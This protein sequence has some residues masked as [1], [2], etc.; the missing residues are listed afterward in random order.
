MAGV[1]VQTRDRSAGLRNEKG[2]NRRRLMFLQDERGHFIGALLFL[3]RGSGVE[4]R[5]DERDD[6]SAVADDVDLNARLMEF[7]R[8]LAA[9]FHHVPKQ[10]ELLTR[11]A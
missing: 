10:P 1:A 6:D 11:R 9:Q 2:A 4:R 7:D 5:V 8:E 3:L